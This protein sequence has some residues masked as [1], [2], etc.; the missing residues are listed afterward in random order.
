[1]LV[2]SMFLAVFPFFGVHAEESPDVFVGV[3]IAYGGVEDVKRLADEVAAYTNLFVLGCTGVTQ[4]R[5]KLEEA[6]QYLFDKGLYFV[7]Y[8]EYPL[9]YNWFSITKSDWLEYAKDRW[10]SRF[11]GIYYT[12]EVGGRQLDHVTDWMTVKQADNYLDADSQFNT[13]ISDA[14]SWF[15]D[16]YSGGNDVSLFTSDYAL[17]WF[18]YRAGY[19]VVL[20]QLGWN[21][22]RQLNAALCRGAATALDKE[23]G[24]MITW[25]YKQPPYME[26]GSELYSDLLLAYD[27]GAKY[28]MIFDSNKDYTASTLEEQHFDALKN[29]WQYT[30]QNPRKTSPISERTAFVLPEGYA[31]GFRG[32]NDKIWGLWEADE[33]STPISMGLSGTFGQFDS[34]LDIIYEDAIRHNSS[35]EYKALIYWNDSLLT[36]PPPSV[37]ATKPTEAIEPLAPLETLLDGFFFLGLPV[38]L[39]VVATILIAT[40]GFF[41]II[42]GKRPKQKLV[43]IS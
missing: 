27:N 19:D 43:T 26:S 25:T 36:S 5:P 11:L 12:D 28:I 20:A 10:G 16:G 38:V 32:P 3:D 4:D 33:L 17:Y 13:K 29:F 15:R 42:R 14:V 9:D 1:M 31:Y 22:S 41:F 18:D 40:A 7:V 39:V 23:W 2:G 21:Y 24:A 8:Q 35:Q 34:N 30:Q 6:C 37:I